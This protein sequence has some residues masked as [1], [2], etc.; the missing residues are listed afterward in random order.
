ME[1]I[2][3]LTEALQQIHVHARRI[4]QY[5][6]EEIDLEEKAIEE[7]EGCSGPLKRRNPPKMK[8]PG[9]LTI[10]CTIGNVKIGKALLDSRS[11]INLMPLSMLKKI[12]GLTLKL[13]NISSVVVDGSSK[14]LYDVVE[15]VVIRIESLEFLVDFVVI[16][17]KEDDRILVILGRSFMKM[18]KVVISVYYGVIML[19]DQEEK[20]IYNLSK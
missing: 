5:L 10:P 19:K 1:I 16:E 14:K 11:S 20:V 17:M 3:L 6:G 8:D 2:M 4:K 7:H 9:G 12:G 18:A 13:T 15:D